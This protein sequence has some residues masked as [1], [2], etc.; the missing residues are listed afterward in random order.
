MHKT[1][2]SDRIA[3][4]HRSS[5]KISEHDEQRL[6]KLYMQDKSSKPKILIYTCWK[7][8]EASN[9]NSYTTPHCNHWWTVR[10][11][12][13]Q[14]DCTKII[15]CKNLPSWTSKLKAWNS[16]LDPPDSRR[17]PQ[18]KLNLK[19]LSFEMQGSSV[20][21]LYLKLDLSASFALIFLTKPDSPLLLLNL[22]VSVTYLTKCSCSF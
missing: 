14:H 8:V 3:E 2:I 4:P 18:V 1:A 19:C 10:I 5:V 12:E 22:I 7:V 15:S 21:V 9:S 6:H 17:D 13:Q 16:R 20:I 11:S